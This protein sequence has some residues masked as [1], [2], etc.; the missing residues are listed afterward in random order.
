MGSALRI[1][2]ED[3]G[4]VQSRLSDTVVVECTR[5]ASK[6]SSGFGTASSAF[7]NSDCLLILMSERN[8]VFR[9]GVTLSGKSDSSFK[10][11][12]SVPS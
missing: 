5:R 7:F 4:T 3:V 10:K 12:L 8:L 2:V 9:L 6:A 11:S 1:N